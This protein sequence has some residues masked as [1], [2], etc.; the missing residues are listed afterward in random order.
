[1]DDR[2][3][4]AWL[5][6]RAGFGL[7]PDALTGA[8]ERGPDAEL[9]RLLDPD[10]AG[11]APTGDPW[12]GLALDPQ[13][14]GRREAVIGWLQHLLTSER[15]LADRR[16]WILH[17]WLVSSM[18]KVNVPELMVEQ[19][20]MFMTQGG[21][22]FPDL[23]RSLTV[24]RA[25]L[26]YLD[27]RTSTGTAPNENYGRELLE[28]FALGLGQYVEDDVQAAARALTGWVVG[29]NLSEARF[30]PSRHD[31]TPVTLL[32]VSGVHDVDTVVDAVVS[33]PAHPGFVA[34]RIVAE[35]VG[36]PDD[37]RLAGVVDQLATIYVEHDMTLDP[38]IAAALR[39]GL[40]GIS[41]PLVAAPIPWLVGAAR[42]TGTAGNGFLR[43]AQGRV[44]ELGQL[45]LLPPSVA[46]WPTGDEWF[47]ASSLIARTNMAAAMSES[48]AAGEP[49]RAAADDGDLDLLAQRL[50]LT[51]PF[52]PSTAAAL[53][54]EPDP[55]NRLTLALV[56]PEYL[57][58]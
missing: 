15:P 58:T 33:H 2:Q 22:S 48:A 20:R 41:T 56:S 13:N 57:L 30:V 37:P 47:T 3:A 34:R 35:L 21:G 5:H 50:G 55:V 12:E 23:L 14:D 18:A 6:R 17:G 8:V 19:I 46:G 27:G 10:G 32:G 1:M 9:S 24:N 28:L 51:E 42:A 38:V 54:N 49:V 52:L 26:V 25:M 53:R 36:D 40:D 31:D 43:S 7:H 45:P 4:V 44:R 16:T 11:I 39:L 29:R